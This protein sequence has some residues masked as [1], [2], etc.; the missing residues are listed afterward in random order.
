MIAGKIINS[1]LGLIRTTVLYLED[2]VQKTFERRPRA[3][4]ACRPDGILTG[5]MSSR[6]YGELALGMNWL[7]LN[8]YFP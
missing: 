6:D 3:G 1:P 4:G 7:H 8:N 5:L 2:A